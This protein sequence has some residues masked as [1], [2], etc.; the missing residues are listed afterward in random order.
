MRNQPQYSV[1]SVDHA[2]RLATL[3]QQ[4]G[5]LRVTDA[6]NLIGVAP[7][8]A[9]RLLT[10][11]VYRDFAEQLPD[12]RYG[13]GKVLR[14]AVGAEAP[15]AQLRRVALPHLRSLVRQIG[16]TV[17]LTVLAGTEM[18]VVATVESDHLLRVGNRMGRAL[19]ADRTAGGRAMLALLPKA[20]LAARYRD[21]DVDLAKLASVLASVRR[22]GHAINNQLTET[23]VTA[24]GVALRDP[25]GQPVGAL[26]LAMPTVRFDRNR[27][28]SWVAALHEAAAQVEA[29]LMP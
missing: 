7:S 8:T 1:S 16:E 24:V 28:T 26:A 13:P 9:H 20:E 14:P 23:G 3:L 29:G 25:E 21:E 15:V 10:M 12:R 22:R 6:A 17:N 5:A 18:R 27:L 19:P 4:E 11:L 2:L